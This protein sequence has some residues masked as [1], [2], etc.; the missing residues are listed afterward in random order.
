MKGRMSRKRIRGT[1]IRREGANCRLQHELRQILL[2]E[3]EICIIINTPDPYLILQ[4]YDKKNMLW[5]KQKFKILL[6]SM[7]DFHFQALGR[8]PQ[9]SRDTFKP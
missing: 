3:M 6:A 1:L 9:L 2:H 7:E 5:L 8:S 4:V